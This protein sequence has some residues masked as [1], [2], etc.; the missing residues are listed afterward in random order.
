[1]QTLSNHTS[2]KP[3][4]G[5]KIVI[6]E[7]HDDTRRY[8]GLFLGRLGA[9]VVLAR[10]ALEGVEA[11][12]NNRPN[13]ALCDIQMPGANGFQL[14]RQT[15]ALGPNDGG[16]VP[17]VAMTSLTTQ[18]D[19]ARILNAG[20]EAYLSKPFTPNTLTATILTVARN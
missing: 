7:D 2:R 14:L 4:S 19:R 11:I 3:L 18:A 20:F 5:L 8:L 16:S 9:G 10:N 6:V 13:L 17:L 1:M 15:R 12:K